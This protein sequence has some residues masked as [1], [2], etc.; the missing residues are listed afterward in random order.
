MA[1]SGA[2]EDGHSQNAHGGNRAD[3]EA[4]HNRRGDEE[5]G[6]RPGDD[7]ERGRMGERAD[8]FIL[9]TLDKLG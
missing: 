4:V 6:Q 5:A 3:G 2:R 1:R 9:L 8:A 7:Q